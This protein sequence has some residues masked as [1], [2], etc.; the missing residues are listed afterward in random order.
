MDDCLAFGRAFADKT[1]RSNARIQ[2]AWPKGAYGALDSQYHPAG[3]DRETLRRLAK[4]SKRIPLDIVK[5]ELS[6]VIQERVRREVKMLH[7]SDIELA[8]AEIEG[9]A[10]ASNDRV[11][12]GNL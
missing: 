11:G 5:R 3:I 10:E 12:G 4:T 6:I 9:T 2:A 7:L 1:H 8:I